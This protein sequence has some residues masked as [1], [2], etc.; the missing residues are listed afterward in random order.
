MPS[1]VE[2]TI[3]L[4]DMKAGCGV[5]LLRRLDLRW[6]NTIILLHRHRLSI[7][8][9]RNLLG[10]ESKKSRSGVSFEKNEQNVASSK[11]KE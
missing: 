5:L 11:D 8:S 6:C 4:L 1:R 2:T 7:L 3:A 10:R 9:R